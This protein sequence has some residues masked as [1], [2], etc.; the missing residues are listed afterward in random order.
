MLTRDEIKHRRDTLLAK[1]G[2]RRKFTRRAK[3]FRLD[4][5]EALDW[6]RLEGYDYLLNATASTD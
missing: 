3:A 1:Y 6:A 2:G 4:T 5:D